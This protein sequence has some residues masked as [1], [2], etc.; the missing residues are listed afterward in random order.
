VRYSL[1]HDGA[2]SPDAFRG[3]THSD[4]ELLGSW[5]KMRS[6]SKFEKPC[7]RCGETAPSVM[8][9]VRHM[10]KLSHKREATGFKRILRAINRKQI[11]VCKACHGKI[12]RGEYDHLKLS[13]L[14]YLARSRAKQR[15]S[16]R[17]GCAERCLSGSE[18]NRWKR[19][20][21]VPRWRF[22]L[23]CPDGLPSKRR[24]WRICYPFSIL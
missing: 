1:N 19:A 12:H 8:H 18:G 21:L 24:G 22:T 6:R 5:I 16:W 17:A 9:Q 15:D 3:G 14:A 20:I 13:T 2:K 10:R 7:C 23:L 4:I 11:P